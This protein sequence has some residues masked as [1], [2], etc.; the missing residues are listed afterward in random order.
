MGAC[1]Y[2]CWNQKDSTVDVG[3]DLKE[4]FWENGY[5]QEAMKVIIAFWHK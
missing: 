5:M 2:H 3:Y 4:E 1:G